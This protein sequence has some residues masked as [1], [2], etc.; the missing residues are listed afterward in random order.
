MQL[1][2]MKIFYSSASLV[3]DTIPG[4]SV[5]TKRTGTDGRSGCFQQTG[6]L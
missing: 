1:W 4:P 2:V 3:S 6:G 5:F